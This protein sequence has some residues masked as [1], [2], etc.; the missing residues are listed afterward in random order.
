MDSDSTVAT[1]SLNED[2]KYE[3]RLDSAMKMDNTL[4]D[5]EMRGRRPQSLR[6]LTVLYHR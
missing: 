3:G 5:D 6:T 2:E 1:L 4:M